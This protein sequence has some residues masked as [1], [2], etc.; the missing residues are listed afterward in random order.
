[1][2]DPY[3]V[4]G[5]KQGASIDEVKRAYRELARKYHPD[6]NKSEEARKKF[7]EITAA[8]NQILNSSNNDFNFLLEGFQFEE[9]PIDFDT[10]IATVGKAIGVEAQY[11]ITFRCPLCGKKWKEKSFLKVDEEVEEICQDCLS[12]L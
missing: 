4:L 3:Q 8:Y 5:L 7:E 6:L 11:E 9:E 10:I 12:S 2:S 1:M